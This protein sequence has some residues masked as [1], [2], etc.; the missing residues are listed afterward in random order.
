MTDLQLD[1]AVAKLIQYAKDKKTIS[2]D[3]L[4]DFLPEQIVNSDKMDAVL[5]LLEANNVQI[6]E[7]EAAGEDEAELEEPK[8]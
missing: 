5:A 4:S 3:E 7:D 8:A 2:Y 1:P 6:I